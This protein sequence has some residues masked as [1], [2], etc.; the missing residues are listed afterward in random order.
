MVQF[1]F[2]KIHSKIYATNAHEIAHGCR[3]YI[4]VYGK[5]IEKCVKLI[6]FSQELVKVSK[7]L[8][9]CVCGLLPDPQN[10]GENIEKIDFSINLCTCVLLVPN[11]FKHLPESFEAT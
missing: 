2:K 6:F 11:N 10:V 8:K 7:I 3:P 1:Y 5:I 4:I 9:F